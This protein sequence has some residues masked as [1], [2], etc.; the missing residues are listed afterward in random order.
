M[1]YNN[2][3]SG[4]NSSVNEFCIVV[5]GFS[6]FLLLFHSKLIFYS[7][8]CIHTDFYNVQMIQAICQAVVPHKNTQW[9]MHVCHHRTH[10]LASLLFRSCYCFSAII[11][12]Q[13]STNPLT[14][15]KCIWSSNELD[16]QKQTELFS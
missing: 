10:G 13:D 4:L 1:L 5:H 15:E 9:K 11:P 14:R 3:I 8:L 7:A 12:K 6:L 2:S 16:A